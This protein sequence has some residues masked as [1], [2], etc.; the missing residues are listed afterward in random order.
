[1]A[2]VGESQTKPAYRPGKVSG[3]APSPRSATRRFATPSK[4]HRLILGVALRAVCR[5]G[6]IRDIEGSSYG[7]RAS[8]GCYH[9]NMLNRTRKPAYART[10]GVDD[11]LIAQEREDP[12][13]LLYGCAKPKVPVNGLLSLQVA[14]IVAT[15]A[16][17][18]V[19]LAMDGFG[20]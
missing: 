12:P 5:R 14:T 4:Y 7:K 19:V 20:G 9:S 6:R 1:M 13:S 16:P 18:G 11:Q 2:A 10:A 17:E 8:W 15:I 3:F